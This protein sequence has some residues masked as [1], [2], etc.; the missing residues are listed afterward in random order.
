M[1]P[2]FKR[3]SNIYLV[4]YYLWEEMFSKFTTYLS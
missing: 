1:Y 4:A 2:A 3:K